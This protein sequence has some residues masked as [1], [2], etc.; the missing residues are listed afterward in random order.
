MN[1]SLEAKAGKTISY[2]LQ[3][4]HKIKNTFHY[5]LKKSEYRALLK[6]LGAHLQIV[7]MLYISTHI[8]M[9]ITEY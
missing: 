8:G 2:S 1:N 6:K 4:K 5:H 9:S 3:K 7:L